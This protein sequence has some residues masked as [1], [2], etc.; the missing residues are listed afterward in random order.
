MKIIVNRY[1]EKNPN[2]FKCDAIWS[3]Y[4]TA[5]N[6]MIVLIVDILFKELSMLQM[7]YTAHKVH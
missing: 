5:N 3:R 7:E 6:Y 1:N 2:C 4:T